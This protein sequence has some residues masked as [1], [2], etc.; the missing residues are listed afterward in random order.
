M[1][2][3]RRT[4]PGFRHHAGSHAKRFISLQHVVVISYAIGAGI[5][6]LGI[7]YGGRSLIRK[8]PFLNK[9]LGKVQKV[10]GWS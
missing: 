10:L 6:L 8:V 7:A 1:G 2:A 4:D 5:P 9:N 3:L